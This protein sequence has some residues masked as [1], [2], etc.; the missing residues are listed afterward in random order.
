MSTSL[1]LPPI[2]L[3]GTTLEGGGQLLRLALSLSSLTSAPVSLTDIRSNR[4]G[5]GGLKPQHLTCVQWLSTACN[6]ALSGASLKS[7]HITFIPDIKRPPHTKL[8]SDDIHIQQATPGSVTLILQAILPFILFSGASKPIRLHITGGTNVSNS[9]S[10]DYITQVLLPMLHLI[11]IPRITATL[12]SR[13][14][15]QGS[16][17]LGTVTYTITPLPNPLS[18]FRLHHRG[19]ITRITATILAPAHT[20]L[21]FRHQLAALFERH[22]SRFFGSTATSLP[23]HSVDITFED[24]RHEKRFYILL[25]ATASTGIKLGRDWLYD[26]AVRPGATDT[27]VPEMVR[28]VAHDLAS[29]IK[30]GGCVDEFLR[31]QLVVF[32]A[33]AKGKSVVFGGYN[34][35]QERVEPSLHA[36]TAH[37]VARKILGV[38]FDG[39]GGCEGVGFWPRGK[40]GTDGCT[41]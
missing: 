33:L 6:A 32:Q 25:V 28:R 38:D 30:H 36:K 23:L 22:E 40:L 41:G 2:H 10:C 39:D 19:T 34:G 1:P 11:G 16:P 5:S 4:R 26:R 14:W 21:H 24:S 9:P 20:E 18:A 15:S 12:H 29:E 17:T 7:K 35:A 8:E 31:D 27:I 13:G 37:W 3:Q